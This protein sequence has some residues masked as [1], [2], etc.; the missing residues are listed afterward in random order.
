MS[1]PAIVNRTLFLRCRSKVWA[2]SSAGS[3]P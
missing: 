2:I 1:T 3:E